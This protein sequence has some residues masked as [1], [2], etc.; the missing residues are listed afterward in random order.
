MTSSYVDTPSLVF[1]GVS[2]IAESTSKNSAV[3]A[4]NSITF[5]IS[6]GEALGLISRVTDGANAVIQLLAGTDQ[7]S[8]GVVLVR[9]RIA[10]LDQSTELDVGETLRVGLT[11]TAMNLGINGKKLKN[12]VS[13][14]LTELDLELHAETVVGEMEAVDAERARL[15]AVLS[16]D[17]DLLIIRNPPARGAAIVEEQGR[18]I[19]GQYL[20]R[21]G[22]VLVVE[23]APRIMRRICQRMVWLRDGEIIMDGPR[24]YVSRE[25]NRSISFASDKTKLA[26][27]FRRF[28]RQY[29]GVELELIEK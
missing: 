2:T 5:Y 23:E 6:K 16:A 8:K 25:F 28:K 15:L 9:S 11:R 19:I 18:Y 10:W 17:P 3:A 26:Q 27:L 4:L 12:T 1:D 21:G 29:I 7:P 24:T 14:V 13:A 22:S 20:E